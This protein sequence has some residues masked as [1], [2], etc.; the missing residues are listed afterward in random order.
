MDVRGQ[1]HIPDALL[2]GKKRPYPLDRRPQGRSGRSLIKKNVAL[3]GNR[4]PVAELIAPLPTELSVSRKECCSDR[5]HSEIRRMGFPRTE[6]M[7]AITKT[8]LYS[9]IRPCHGL[10]KPSIICY[11]GETPTKIGNRSSRILLERYHFMPV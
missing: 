10:K 3:T 9:N 4:T 5:M 8:R 7:N 1:L 2:P 11:D 6:G